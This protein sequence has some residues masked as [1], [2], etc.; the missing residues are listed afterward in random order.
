MQRNSDVGRNL[1]PS[2][3]CRKSQEYKFCS[4]TPFPP[5]KPSAQSVIFLQKESCIG[6]QNGFGSSLSAFPIF[7]CG[8]CRRYIR[9]ISGIYRICYPLYGDSDRHENGKRNGQPEIYEEGKTKVVARYYP[10]LP[11][12]Y[13]SGSH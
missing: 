12:N 3:K 11:Y 10:I 9:V 1:E 6:K 2:K 7:L 13:H 5:S 4:S 8:L